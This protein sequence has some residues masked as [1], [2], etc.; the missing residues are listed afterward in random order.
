MFSIIAFISF[1]IAVFYNESIAN[2]FIWPVAIILFSALVFASYNLSDSTT[3]VVSENVT[4]VDSSNSYSTYEYE[5]TTTYFRE[6]AF[7]WMFLVLAMLS[8]ILFIWDIWKKWSDEVLPPVDTV[9]DNVINSKNNNSLMKK[10]NE[11]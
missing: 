1:F 9:V 3:V 8:V 5:P 10:N 11:K 7:S 4:I 2:L 6:V